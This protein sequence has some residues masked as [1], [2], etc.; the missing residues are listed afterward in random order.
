VRNAPSRRSG[1]TLLEVLVS[2]AIFLG[3]LTAIMQL[4]ALG[5]QAELMA[6]LDSEAILRCE[7]KMGE[8]ICGLEPLNNGTGQQ[9]DDAAPGWTYD[10]VVDATGTEG[11]LQVTVTVNHVVGG[12]LVNSTFTL[13][14]LIRDPQL[15]LDAAVA[16]ES[17]E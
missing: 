6:R 16:S 8:L 4:F 13:V 9:F 10:V 3:A 1:L 12:D 2:T 7:S 14:R 11:L 5:N 15:F 17:S